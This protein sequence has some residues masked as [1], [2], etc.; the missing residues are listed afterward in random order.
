MLSTQLITF[1]K[2]A[3]MLHAS[4]EFITKHWDTYRWTPNLRD[5]R[6]PVRSPHSSHNSHQC[7]CSLRLWL[8]LNVLQRLFLLLTPTSTSLWTLLAFPAAARANPPNQPQWQVPLRMP[9]G[10]SL[11]PRSAENQTLQRIPASQNL[12]L[13]TLLAPP[14]MLCHTLQS[15]HFVLTPLPAR[16]S[17][18]LGYT[19]FMQF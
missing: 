6:H 17:Q 12:I 18:G 9:S 5:N 1:N 16:I 15:H 13:S 14:N 10:R 11:W 2:S 7:R 8:P 4:Q 19:Q 3:K